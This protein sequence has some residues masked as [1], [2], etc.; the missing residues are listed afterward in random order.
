MKKDRKGT[1]REKEV[2]AGICQESNTV[3]TVGNY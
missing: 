1:A 2:G 3:E